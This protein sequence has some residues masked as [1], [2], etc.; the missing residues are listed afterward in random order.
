MNNSL[1]S[2]TTN[3]DVLHLPDELRGPGS[4]VARQ[5]TYWVLKNS[6]GLCYRIHFK[7][8]AEFAFDNPTYNEVLL[9]KQHPLLFDHNQ[10]MQTLMVSMPPSDPEH[11]ARLLDTKIREYTKQW[12]TLADYANIDPM[13]LLQGGHG[14]L[15]TAPELL[16]K[17]LLPIL[18]EAGTRPYYLPG[19]SSNGGE[20]HQ[21]LLLLG[22]SYVI[23]REFSVVQTDTI[24]PPS[25]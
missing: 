14:V 8:K 3:K 2:T 13:Q 22:K 4:I 7:D 9:L 19:Q 6:K 23:A 18:N 24:V 1:S 20:P 10:K 12:R 25:R 21:R 5:T 11:T 17:E 15:M 16:C